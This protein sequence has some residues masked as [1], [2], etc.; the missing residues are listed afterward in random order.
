LDLAIAPNGNILVSS[1]Y[2]YG[3][4]TSV[5]SVREYHRLTGELIRVFSPPAGITFC[6][7]RGLR[8]GPDGHLYCVA[9]DEVLMFDFDSGNFL[10]VVISYPHL[11]GQ[12]IEFFGD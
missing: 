8:F 10:D 4:S 7:P 6:H 11:H 3:Q 2:P 1:E 5:T 9:Q 12:A